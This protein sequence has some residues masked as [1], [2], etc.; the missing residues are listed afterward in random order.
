MPPAATAD[1][2]VYSTPTCPWC[3]KAKE[4]LRSQRVPFV[5]RDVS[6]DR[7]AADEMVRRTRQMGVPV[8]ADAE[9]AIVGFDYPKL[10]RL[11]ERHRP[12]PGLG[13]KVTTAPGAQNG[14]YV[15][16]VRDASPAQRAGVLAGDVIQE[17]SGAPVANADDLERL[18]AKRPQGQPTSM[19]VRRDGERRTLII[20]G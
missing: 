19:L 8:I 6:V 1:V 13:L 10:Q 18:A 15:G 3:A 17:L 16:A 20:R 11:A 9:E 14:A 5:E 7:P 4:F 2:T 12:A